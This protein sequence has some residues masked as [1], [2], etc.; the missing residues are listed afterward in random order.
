MNL[1]KAKPILALL[2]TSAIWGIA[3][4]VI[5]YTLQSIPPFTFLALRMLV[6]AIIITPLIAAGG[7]F[8]EL[9]KEGLGKLTGLA[10]LGQTLS[11][12]LVFL[13][14][15]KTS[16]IE[17]ALIGAIF[18]VMLVMG[19]ALFLKEEITKLERIGIV[20]TFLGTAT[21]IFLEPLLKAKASLAITNIEGNFLVFL[22]GISW[23]AYVIL[24]KRRFIGE[25][26][27]KYRFEGMGFSFIVAFISFIPLSLIE[28][29]GAPIAISYQAILGILYMGALSSVVAYIAYDYGLSKIEA[30]ETGIF[31][32]LSPL[33]TLP[34]AFI[35]LGEIPS[36]YLIPGTALILGGFY[37]SEKKDP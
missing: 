14:L 37:L 11:L 8:K 3:G 2:I 10:L 24:E 26:R 6:A 4:P 20:L 29:T 12:T 31:S 27:R 13:G 23:L 33:F 22:G 30:S 35:L 16:A 32:Y 25:R 5:K 19:G 9:K 15:Q 1:K 34:A 18:P 7:G 21:I 36:I 28:L 17:N